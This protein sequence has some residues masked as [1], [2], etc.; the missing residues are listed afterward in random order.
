MHAALLAVHALPTTALMLAAL[1][2]ALNY[3]VMTGYDLVAFRYAGAELPRRHIVFASFVSYAISNSVGLAMLSGTSVRFRF[4]ARWG[5]RA[6][7]L[8]RIVFSYS[9]TFWLGLFGLGGLSLIVTGR[10]PVAG[11]LLIGVVACYVAAALVW[12]RPIRIWRWTWP[13]PSLAIAAAQITL[14]SVDWILAALVPYV[15]LP[16]HAIGFLTFAAC[17]LAA[18]LAGLVSHVPGGL[19]VFD[20][21]LVLLLSSQVPAS[22]LVPALLAYRAI[23]YLA[24]FVV[25]VVLL[26]GFEAAVRWRGPGA[27]SRIERAL[28][29]ITR[30]TLPAMVFAVGLVLLF[31]GATPP[32]SARLS[33]LAA[34]VPVSVIEASHFLGSV[35]GVLL[36]LLSQGLARRLDAAWLAAVAT[37]ALGIVTSLL[38]GLDYEEAVA[39]T[40]V[41]AALIYAR[42][43]F[44]RRAAFFATRFSASWT[45]AVL[46]GLGAS[47]FLGFVAF[48][49]VAY[50]DDLWWQF[51][52]EGNASRFLRASVGAATVL[53]AA[54]VARLARPAPHVFI[55]PSAADLETAD[56]IIRAQSRTLPNLA[57]LRDKSLLFNADRTGFVMYGVRGRT[58]VALGDPVGP[59]EVA[60][61]LIRD[62]LERCHDFHGTPAFYQ[63]TPA[64]LPRYAE[65][66]LT[67]VKLGEEAHVDLDAFTLEGPR[68]ASA[69]QAMRRLAKD[70]ASFAVIDPARTAIDIDA[71]RRVSDDWLARRNSGEKGFSLGFFDATYLTRGPI[72][73]VTRNG[74]IDAFANLWIGADHREASIDLMRH[75]ATAPKVTME[76]LITHLLVWAKTQGF[77]RF[78]LGMAPLSGFAPSRAASRWTRLGGLLYRHGDRVYRFRGL[79]AFKDKFHPE[80]ESRYLAYPGGLYLPR[81]LRDVSALI[82]GGYRQIFLR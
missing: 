61:E 75:T 55:A 74:A 58:W 82:A 14:S 24:P 45:M 15:L 26:A 29:L 35:A 6:E 71:L 66:G 51:T 39:I 41:L 33:W 79:R 65:F 52:F 72:A 8:A 42:P 36:L 20:A 73:V 43:M 38:K 59:V 49:E 63:V 17:F 80:W 7:T 48:R 62:F 16:A 1:L 2:T 9:V 70:G 67:F 78:A 81:V 11:A 4:Y 57:F 46:T 19:G 40:L 60:D 34:H 10:A 50:T 44:R 12:R 76:A 37:L 54:V 47:V 21:T 23:Y 53:L 22:V 27:T 31:S 25:G 64:Y 56:A 32:V 68:G 13:I 69:R 28:A 77:A 3:A 18:M 30:S 5:V